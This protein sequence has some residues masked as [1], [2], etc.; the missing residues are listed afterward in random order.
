[1]ALFQKY[2]FVCDPD[3]CDSLVEFTCR[4]SFDFPSGSVQHKC[5]CGRDMT[6]VST[7]T[8]PEEPNQVRALEE[9]N[10]KQAEMIQQLQDRI[11]NDSVKHMERLNALQSKINK[12]IDNLT[13]EYWYDSDCDKSTVLEEICEILGHEPKQTITFSAQVIVEGS[14]DV[15]LS[16]LEDFDLRYFLQDELSV[17][18]HNGDIVIESF[19]IDYVNQGS[20]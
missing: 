5:A 14:V 18:A 8:V 12:I 19:D 1:M 15:E 6:L 17:D 9:H 7:S 11:T 2:T 16:E 20:F 4:T 13:M 10:Q 3:E